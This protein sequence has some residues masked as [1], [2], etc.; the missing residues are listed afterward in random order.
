MADQDGYTIQS[1]NDLLRTCVLK[2]E[3]SWLECLPSIEFTYN[4]SFHLSIEMT[5]FETLYERRCR[6][7]LHWYESRESVLLGAEVV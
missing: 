3:V 7:P 2:Q 1:L 6:T 5:P 4:N